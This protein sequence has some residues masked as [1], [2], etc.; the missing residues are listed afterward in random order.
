M[1]RLCG[2]YYQACEEEGSLGRRIE[3]Q[4]DS[5]I[6]PFPIYMVRIEESTGGYS[7]KCIYICVCVSFPCGMVWH[8]ERLE[9]RQLEE[10]YHTSSRSMCVLQSTTQHS[11]AQHTSR[12]QHST[13]QPWPG[14]GQPRLQIGHEKGGGSM[15]A[16]G[17]DPL[18]DPQLP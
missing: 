9:Y 13:A 2:S 10:S 5:M 12:A 8:V 4:E 18:S 3:D 17:S 1:W 6:D 7:M 16:H 15:R 11:T 14:A